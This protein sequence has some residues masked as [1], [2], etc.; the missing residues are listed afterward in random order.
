MH[1]CGA[2]I[3]LEAL[4]NDSSKRVWWERVLSLSLLASQTIIWMKRMLHSLLSYLVLANHK[5]VM[6]ENNG[7]ICSRSKRE[8]EK[9][10][11]R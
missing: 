5:W 3:V 9:A 1:A 7:L 8:E 6:D 4:F 2:K 11:L 10:K